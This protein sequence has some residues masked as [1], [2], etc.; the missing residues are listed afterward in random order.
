M[1]SEEFR[2]SALRR[3]RLKTDYTHRVSAMTLE[4]EAGR[5]LRLHKYQGRFMDVVQVLRQRHQEKFADV[6]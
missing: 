1:G 5:R 4:F 3:V 6:S 2:L